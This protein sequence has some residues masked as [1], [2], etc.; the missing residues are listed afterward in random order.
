MEEAPRP[1]FA[2]WLDYFEANAQRSDDVPWDKKEELSPAE[3]SVLRSS[4]AK[5]QL[6]EYSE[7]HSLLRGA[8]AEADRFS[9]PE[10]V[11]ITRYFIKE[12]QG[13]ALLLKR[14]M[15]ANDLPVLRRSWTDSVFRAPRKHVPFEVSVTILITAE[16]IALTY[17]KAL[18]GA[19]TSQVLPAIC[20][21]ILEEETAHVD[22]ESGLLAHLRRGA[23]H[24][25]LADRAHRFLYFGTVL[26]VFWDH[27]AVLR[28]GGYGLSGFWRSSWSEF[29][30]WL[31]H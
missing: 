21:R 19:T 16:L 27:R 25:F 31:R 7:G 10:L 20:E 2:S 22:Y 23:V 24:A 30:R 14:Y 6:G 5:F 8:Q 9:A 28:A 12:E 18:R 15:V 17:Y 1:D 29:D 11:P 26:V 13:H 3:R 4:I